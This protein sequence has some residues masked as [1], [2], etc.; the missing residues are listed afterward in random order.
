[1]PPWLVHWTTGWG[2]SCKR[3]RHKTSLIT[4][5]YSSL[6]TMVPRPEE[7]VEIRHFEDS[8]LIPWKAVFVSHSQFN[9]RRDS[10]DRF[11]ILNQSR[12]WTSWRLRLLLP[13]FNYRPIAP[14]T[15]SI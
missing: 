10:Q 13:A 15:A 9:G 3:S 2:N 5:S 8:N 4:L 1:M 12:L 14:M 11:P 6:V 7:V